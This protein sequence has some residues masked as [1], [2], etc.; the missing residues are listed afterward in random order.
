[1]LISQVDLIQRISVTGNL[2]LV[3][4][5]RGTV[6]IDNGG[7]TLVAGHNALDGIGTFDGL[8]LC[9][10]FQLRKNLRVFV[11]AHACHG[12]QRCNIG[13]EVHKFCRQQ[14]VVQK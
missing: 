5:Q 3:V 2:R 12:F 7:D 13:S 1:M 9:D 6:L 4:V 10:G 11:L 8:Y 14:T